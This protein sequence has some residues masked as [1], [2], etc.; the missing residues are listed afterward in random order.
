MRLQM[1]AVAKTRPYRV[2]EW[3]GVIIRKEECNK[4]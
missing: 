2:Y 3:M 4:Y 1:P